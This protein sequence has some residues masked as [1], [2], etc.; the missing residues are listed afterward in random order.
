MSKIRHNIYE[1]TNEKALI[2]AH[3]ARKINV[4]TVNDTK[5]SGQTDENQLRLASK[6]NR[7]LYSH[8]VADYCKL[9]KAFMAKGE[10]HGGIALLTQ[11]Y[12]VGAR[13]KVLSTLV[14]ERSAESMI[15]Q[16]EFLSQ[17]L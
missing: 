5:T 4:L 17:Y 2:S 11:D 14:L 9:H 3:R 13:L 1:A 10:S 7:V 6:E 16:V 8:N 15:D 12:S